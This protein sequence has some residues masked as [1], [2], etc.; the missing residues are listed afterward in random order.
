MSKSKGLGNVLRLPGLC[1][2]CS[3]GLKSS[4][5]SELLKGEKGQRCIH[6]LSAIYF[7]SHNLKYS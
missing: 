1:M 7:D 4:Q 5:D 2:N 6:S 3:R